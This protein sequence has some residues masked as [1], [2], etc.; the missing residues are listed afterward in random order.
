MC[1]KRKKAAPA[2]PPFASV[3]YTEA[4]KGVQ[5][6]CMATHAR[7]ALCYDVMRL[8]RTGPHPHPTAQT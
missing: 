8:W 2:G 1:A 6:R 4:M 7:L 5:P 3:A